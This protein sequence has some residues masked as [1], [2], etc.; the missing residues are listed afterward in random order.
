M[1][2]T[3]KNVISGLILAFAVI[4]VCQSKNNLARLR[5]TRSLYPYL[6]IRNW[7]TFADGAS[8]R[9][10]ALAWHPTEQC[11]AIAGGPRSTLAQLRLYSVVGD[12]TG[13]RMEPVT[14]VD[15]ESSG[16]DTSY[17]ANALAWNAAGTYLGVGSNGTATKQ[18]RVY[19]YANNTLTESISVNWNT[20]TAGVV[21][22]VSWHPGGKYVAIGGTGQAS[23]YQ[24]IVYAVDAITPQLTAVVG[25]KLGTS[26]T[27]YSVA[28]DATGNY[29]AVGCGQ[30]STGKA[31][32]QMYQ[33]TDGG[34]FGSYALTQKSTYD[35]GGSSAYVKDVAWSPNG[36]YLAV[37][38][39]VGTGT[40]ELMLFKAQSGA[41]AMVSGSE[42]DFG[43]PNEFGYGTVFVNTLAWD[44]EGTYLLVGGRGQTSQQQ[45]IM[46]QLE[47]DTLTPRR[48]S[49]IK[50]GTADATSVAALAWQPSRQFVLIGGYS[51]SNSKELWLAEFL[52]AKPS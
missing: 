22:T 44:P 37:G 7:G 3:M 30:E 34:L 48:G 14:S 40:Y 39:Y 13:A 24:V 26:S 35:F 9:L 43:A 45:A 47:N 50:F 11:F 16:H 29:L 41:L 49:Q 1:K 20:T 36:T 23:S 51:A 10:R 21:N 19:S 28:W 32:L 2:T 15:V 52:T 18:F 46:Y 25:L 12:S 6:R 27:V 4:S 17:Q 8:D 38:G 33:F 5:E 42:V 31:A